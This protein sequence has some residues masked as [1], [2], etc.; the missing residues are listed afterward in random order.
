MIKAEVEFDEHNLYVGDFTIEIHFWDKNFM[1]LKSRSESMWFDTLEQ[2][3]SYC[4]E[5]K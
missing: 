4:L 1:V 2:A 3:V 5:N